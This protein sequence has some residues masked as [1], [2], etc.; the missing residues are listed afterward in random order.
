MVKGRDYV[1]GLPRSVRLTTNEVVK[2][3]D[4]E[5]NKIAEA[6]REVFQNTPP[7]LSSDIIDN[8]ITL[9]GGSSQLRNLPEFIFRK[10]G[11]KAKLADDPLFCVAKGLG[12]ALE[13][14]DMYKRVL[15]VKK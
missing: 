6:I 5:L 3:I 2:S 4:V 14:L 12:I 11:V 10:T 8:G 15:L 13:H 1:T 9:T 7:E